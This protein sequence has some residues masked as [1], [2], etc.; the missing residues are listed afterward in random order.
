MCQPD[1]AAKFGDFYVQSGETVRVLFGDIY[2]LTRRDL[3]AL[4]KLRDIFDEAHRVSTEHGAKLVVAFLPGKIR[5]YQDVIRTPENSTLPAEP[6]DLPQRIRSILADITPDIGF[7]DLT[8][9]FTE[10]VNQGQRLFLEGDTHWG[11][12][13]HEVAAQTIYEYLQ[14]HELNSGAKPP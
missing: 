5:V 14:H 13:G 1:S 12:L 9:P 3:I 7:V 10:G 4:N 2:Q 8:P 11:K 6:N